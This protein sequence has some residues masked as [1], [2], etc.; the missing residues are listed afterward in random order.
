[1]LGLYCLSLGGFM[2]LLFN[3][4]TYSVFEPLLVGAIQKTLLMLR[5]IFNLYNYAPCFSASFLFG[6]Y[7]LLEKLTTLLNSWM[8]FRE[9]GYINV[10][11]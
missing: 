7:L 8:Q 3:T 9:P 5:L 1:M 11:K 2:F 10:Y 4:V 6:H